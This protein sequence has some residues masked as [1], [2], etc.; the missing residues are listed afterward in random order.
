MQMLG[1]Q[2]LAVQAQQAGQVGTLC[3]DSARL[4]YGLPFKH[5]EGAGVQRKCQGKMFS[6]NV[7]SS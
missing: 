2:F 6:E 7:N 1:C 4:A 3:W 5:P